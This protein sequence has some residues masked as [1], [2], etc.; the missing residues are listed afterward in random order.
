MKVLIQD[1]YK[2]Q[3]SNFFKKG[4]TLALFSGVTYGLY[5]AFLTMA[6]RK[7]VWEDWTGANTAGSVSYTHLDVYKRQRQIN[8]RAL[9]Y[10]NR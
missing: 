7:G 1:V 8:N 3:A 2:R 5:T 9:V 10:S 6:M 4:I